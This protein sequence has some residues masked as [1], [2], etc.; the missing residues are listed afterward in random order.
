L[1]RAEDGVEVC[2][3]FG[4]NESVVF[5]IEGIKELAPAEWECF[6]EISDDQ[7]FDGGF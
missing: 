4:G 2:E 5:G 7:G 1:D 3:C 6:R